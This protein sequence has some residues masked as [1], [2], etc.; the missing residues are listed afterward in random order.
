MKGKSKKIFVTGAEGFIG[1]HLVEKLV[2]NGF[3]V[4]ALVQ[5][6][7]FSSYGWLDSSKVIN[8]IEIEL[9]DIRDLPNM[10]NL[11][12]G[13]DIVAHLAS[14]IA[15]PYS[16]KA[17]SS[18]VDNNVNGTLNIMQAALENDIEKIIHISTS[19]VYGSAKYVPIDEE[20]P[21]QA[22]SP[23]SA[24]KIGAD[25]I[26]FSFYKSFDLPLTIGR[27]FNT[28]GPRQS[29]RA[30][31]PTI[32]SQLLQG[33]K[34]IYLGSLE[35]IRDFNY[36]IDTCNGIISLITCSSNIFGETFNIGS[37]IGVNIKEVVDIISDIINIKPNIKCDKKRIRPEGSEVDRLV[38]NNNKIKNLV[39]FSH[40]YSLKT[41]LSNTIKWMSHPKNLEL[42][43]TNIYNV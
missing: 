7:S 18:Y 19:E 41:G 37:G 30:V 6:N 38:C 5:Y 43:K 4:K 10:K 27:P 22:Q 26:A 16:Y 12:K 33:K 32:I 39:G 14:L 1:S 42:Y 20:H 40:S 25:A 11:M 35:P 31:I 3:N 17:P 24:S 15:I 36:V 9:G 13:S 23:Y 8:D 34:N 21:L 2:E 28:Y 29:S